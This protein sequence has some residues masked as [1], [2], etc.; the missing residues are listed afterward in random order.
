MKVMIPVDETKKEVC[1]SFGRA[2]FFLIYDEETDTTSYVEN[3]GADAQG[4]AGLKA[5][6]CIVDHNANVVITIRAGENAGKVFEAANIK[7][8]KA[9][10]K[11]ALGQLEAYKQNELEELDHY[12]AGF[13]GLQ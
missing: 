12:H 13:H 7:V 2:P 3:P 11:D 10:K 8:Y 1:V 6:Q 4:G 9:C 5:A